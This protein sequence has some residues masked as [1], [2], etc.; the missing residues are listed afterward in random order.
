MH[1]PALSHLPIDWIIIAVFALIVIFDAMRSGSGRASV[2]ALAFPISVFFSDL[3]PHTV[4][5]GNAI[6]SLSTPVLKAGIFVVTFAIIYILTYRI[7][8]TFGGTSRGLIFAILSGL[9]AT[10]V[11][12][13]MWL[14]VPALNA[15]WHFGT[16]VQSIFGATYAIFWIL[17]A[18]LVLAFVRS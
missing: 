16:Q 15:I 5:L 7:I 13:V 2:L 1:I 8:Y 4:L 3:I 10:A 6:A 17:A 18:Y 12:V 9:S 14:Q 11:T